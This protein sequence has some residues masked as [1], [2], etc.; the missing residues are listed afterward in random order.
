LEAG[1][2]EVNKEHFDVRISSARPFVIGHVVNKSTILPYMLPT[3]DI[4]ADYLGELNIPKDLNRQV[5]V[6]DRSGIQWSPRVWFN[7]QLM[8]WKHCAVLNGGLSKWLKELRPTETGDYPPYT[9]NINLDIY[10][11][12]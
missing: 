1:L 10:K 12:E 5:V 7:F 3:P 9:D 8:G 4:F 11:L 6:Y 2:N